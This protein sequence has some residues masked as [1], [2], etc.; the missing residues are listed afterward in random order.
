MTIEVTNPV[1]GPYTPNG[2][3]TDFPFAFKIMSTNEIRVVDASENVIDLGYSVTIASSGE[4]GTVS[5]ASPPGASVGEFYIQA[6][7]AFGQP[8]LYGA[9]TTFN[10]GSLNNPTDRLAAQNIVLKAKQDRSF[11]VPIG[12]S[13][14]TLPPASER[15]G[16][17][18]IFAPDPI[19][20]EMGIRDGSAFKGDPGAAGNVASNLAELKAALVTNDTMIY[21]KR[22]YKWFASSDD[23]ADDDIIVA[24]DYAGF[25]ISQKAAD[26]PAADGN[27]VQVN[28]DRQSSKLGKTVYVTDPPFNAVGDGATDDTAAILAA[29]NSG[30]STIIFPAEK[31]FRTNSTILL[32]SASTLAPKVTLTGG[33]TLKKH[34]TG[35][36]ISIYDQANITIKNLF[37]DGDIDYDESIGGVYRV[38]RTGGYALAIYGE[39][40]QNLKVLNCEFTGY[41]QDCIQV[42]A[43]WPTGSSPGDGNPG[44]TDKSTFSKKV[45]ILGCKFDTWRNTAIHFSGCIDMMIKSCSFELPDGFYP[46]FGNGIF[47]VELNEKVQI[48]GNDFHNIADN[49]IGV[50]EVMNPLNINHDVS[51]VSN[52]IDRV[53][54]PPILISGVDGCLVK[55]NQITNGNMEG[56][57]VS[58]WLGSGIEGASILVKSSNKARTSNVTVDGNTLKNSYEHGIIVYDDVPTDDQY[59]TIGVSIVNNKIDTTGVS[60]TTTTKNGIKLN[61]QN[62]VMVDNNRIANA[63][64]YAIYASGHL[65]S[66][67]KNEI[68][69][70]ALGGITVNNSFWPNTGYIAVTGNTFIGC[71]NAAVTLYMQP[72][73]NLSGNKY[74]SCGTSAS[75]ATFPTDLPVNTAVVIDHSD[76]VTI[77]DDRYYDSGFFGILLKASRN[78]K[79]SNSTFIDNGNITTISDAYRGGVYVMAL[80]TDAYKAHKFTNNKFITSGTQ[81]VAIN[82]DAT[83]DTFSLSSG[84]ELFGTHSSASKLTFNALPTSLH[85]SKTYDWP[86]LADASQQST[87]ITVTGAKIGAMAA[88]SMSVALSGTRLWAEVTAADTVTVYQRNDTGAAVDLASGTLLVSVAV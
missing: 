86:S 65:H 33:G 60:T 35:S 61:V 32:T 72:H 26:L 5:F 19:T 62:P 16:G 67:T 31:T 54:Y 69:N 82:G 38:N 68:V 57:W 18:K 76:Y 88:A 37:L 45:R 11:M 77:S 51:V 85:A 81:K 87:T 8:T 55:S 59:K 75:F 10:P 63:A 78:A 46:A 58:G 43:K 39:N 3:T 30:A 2:V 22:P 4:G 36:H 9:T 74:V 6:D 48:N 56:D 70:P 47:C 7:P 44:P 53:A 14:V 17:N 73:S 25:W 84:D 49:A 42:R 34:H 41:A 71:V 1:A 80:S 23:P 28:L 13:G 52:T 12:E 29:I 27:T 15:I 64:S 40:V 50:G 20:G 83:L 24:S 79:V 21:Q 66:F